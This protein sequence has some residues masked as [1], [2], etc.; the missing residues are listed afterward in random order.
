[1]QTLKFTE[2]SDVWSFGITLVE[3][4]TD[5]G[6]PYPG[7]TNTEVVMKVQAG[8]RPRQPPACPAAMFELMQRCWATEPASRS[9]PLRN[10][11][12][13]CGHCA[14]GAQLLASGTIANQAD[15]RAR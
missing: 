9:V 15:T 8:T 2:A 7:L 6:R 3:I 11:C 1:M 5:G 4:Y 12:P 14:A 13:G 10:S